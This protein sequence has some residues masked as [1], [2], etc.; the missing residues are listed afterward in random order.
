MLKPYLPAVHQQPLLTI[1]KKG[2]DYQ[3]KGKKKGAD[4]HIKLG[5][6]VLHSCRGEADVMLLTTL[7]CWFFSKQTPFFLKAAIRES[8]QM[9]MLRFLWGFSISPFHFFSAQLSFLAEPPK[10]CRAGSMPGQGEQDSGVADGC[11]TT[12]THQTTLKVPRWQ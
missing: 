4:H 8:V 11:S 2:G 9:S 10:K 3:R 7:I 5:D 12:S 1:P 6:Y